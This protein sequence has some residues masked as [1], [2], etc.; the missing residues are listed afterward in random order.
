MSLELELY[1]L[2]VMV[3]AG[4]VLGFL[5]DLVRLARWAS[6]GRGC[7]PVLSDLWFWASALVVV[8]VALMAANWG[9]A[10]A[11]VLLGL[12]GGFGLYMAL[13]SRL[14][15][16]LG[17]AFLWGVARGWRRLREAARR[18]AQALASQGRRAGAG[19]SRRV[20]AVRQRWA[21]WARRWSRWGG[22]ARCWG[23]WGRLGRREAGGVG[24]ERA[25]D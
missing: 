7:I 15:V 5:F 10:R 13:G 8:T 17:S 9:A 2:F 14:V 23:L 22:G 24:G 21:Q 1:A 6:R 25:E 12:A 19:L 3:L 18:G 4:V 16:D 20:R 11:Y